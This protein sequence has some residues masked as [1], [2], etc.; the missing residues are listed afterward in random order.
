MN[1][2][3]QIYHLVH[4]QEN[5]KGELHHKYVKDERKLPN[6]FLGAATT[7]LAQLQVAAL[8]SPDPILIH[9][10]HNIQ[11]AINAH[12]LQVAGLFTQRSNTTATHDPANGPAR[13]LS[14]REIRDAYPLHLYGRNGGE[15]FPNLG[16]QE[17][18]LNTEQS[19]LASNMPAR[20]PVPPPIMIL[21]DPPSLSNTGCD[22]PT[23]PPSSPYDAQTFTQAGQTNV[24]EKPTLQGRDLFSQSF[25]VPAAGNPRKTNNGDFGNDQAQEYINLL[26]YH[27]S[28]VEECYQSTLKHAPVGHTAPKTSIHAHSSQIVWP[29]SRSATSS[30]PKKSGSTNTLPALEELSKLKN[31]PQP[32]LPVPDF[33]SPR[34]ALKQRYVSAGGNAKLEDRAEIAGPA[35]TSIQTTKGARISKE[36][37]EARMND[38]DWVREH[39]PEF[40][41][42]SSPPRGSADSNNQRK[43]GRTSNESDR[44]KNGEKRDRTSSGASGRREKLKRMFS[45]KNSQGEPT[46]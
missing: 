46:E 17:V 9:A 21:N 13:Q 18:T 27:P 14:A 30:P 29:F 16:A 11:D 31:K 3:V 8:A 12:D 35:L 36:E 45:R 1:N 20:K 25:P 32:P 38:V 44:S 26:P 42:G 34:P 7:T 41:L 19:R 15:R 23:P 40:A 5:E 33:I 2:R 37:L 28:A 39:F 24:P 43:S 6:R 22:F 4:D 10:V